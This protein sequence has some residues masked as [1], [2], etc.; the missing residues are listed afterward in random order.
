MPLDD[1][2]RNDTFGKSK[3]SPHAHKRNQSTCS[4]SSYASS[5]YTDMTCPPSP[6]SVYPAPTYQQTLPSVPEASTLPPVPERKSTS[7]PLRVPKKIAN[8]SCLEEPKT[9]IRFASF[10]Y[11]NGTG[12]LSAD[13]VQQI[14]QKGKLPQNI[15]NTPSIAE[16]L[17][18]PTAQPKQ[19]KQHVHH[20]STHIEPAV[21]EALEV[22]EWWDDDSPIRG[23]PGPS[24]P[25]SP[26]PHISVFGQHGYNFSPPGSPGTVTL[27]ITQHTYTSPERPPPP[28]PK[29]N[30]TYSPSDR[31]PPSPPK[32]NTS[33]FLPRIDSTPPAPTDRRRT[34]DSL[35]NLYMGSISH[36]VPYHLPSGEPKI[37]T[38]RL[39][40][41]KTRIS[42]KQGG[43]LA[44]LRCQKF[45]KAKPQVTHCRCT[46]CDEFWRK[47]GH[48]AKAAAG[49]SLYAAMVRHGEVEKPRTDWHSKSTTR[50]IVWEGH[51]LRRMT[52]RNLVMSKERPNG[53][54]FLEGWQMDN[55]RGRTWSVANGVASRATGFMN[56]RKSSAVDLMKRR[57]SG[58]ANSTSESKGKGE[59]T[60]RSFGERLRRA[61]HDK[62]R[63][64]PTETGN[65]ETSGWYL[66]SD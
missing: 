34:F 38:S 65:V 23:E 54:L 30:M 1:L 17:S 11:D 12:A 21:V 57:T 25:T 8:R 48:E 39:P 9:P 33:P 41:P 28:A 16:I 58:V 37:A 36:S 10:S 51:W 24:Q 22:A 64:R 13:V 43:H 52:L 47:H 29:V 62:P 4:V 59:S 55:E 40:L 6:S 26:Q 32:V 61:K 35:Y 50:K 56:E 31:P 5:A 66:D 2:V 53:E 45:R 20:Q 3:P 15:R 27:P 42:Q 46:W 19:I 7:P 49:R 63:K 60:K 18:V 44:S 14:R